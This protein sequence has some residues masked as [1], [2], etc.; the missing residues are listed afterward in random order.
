MNHF[1]TFAS[2]EW[3]EHL[4]TKLALIAAVI[5]VLLAIANPAVALLTPV[6]LKENAEALASSGI[7]V[8]EIEI[9]AMDLWLQFI[10]NTSTAL[11][12][13]LIIFS[14]TFTKEYQNGTLMPLLTKGLRRTTIV[15][16]KSA[17]LV[18]L[19]SVGF[20]C[21]FGIT[22]GYTTYYWDQFVIH[23]VF[24]VGGCWWLLG[25]FWI[26]L[27]A[28]FSSFLKN[29]VQVIAAAAGVY[30][31]LSTIRM[32][33]TIQPY[34]PM[35]LEDSHML[36]TGESGCASYLPAIIVTIAALILFYLCSLILTKN[37]QL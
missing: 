21:Y 33:K 15:H 29:A 7:T 18:L 12:A 24:F 20:W 32:L 28:F 35:H 31:I 27:L 22:Y 1:L 25:I 34:L 13:F 11:A 26:C 6:I 9:T 17:V 16:A 23:S 4:R 37:K 36:L 30:M 14:G 2:K 3:T 19:W 8:S 10:N 5:F